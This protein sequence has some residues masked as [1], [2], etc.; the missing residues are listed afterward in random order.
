M[1]KVLPYQESNESYSELVLLREILPG[2]GSVVPPPSIDRAT[3]FADAQPGVGSD[4]VVMDLEA[5]EEVVVDELEGQSN[6]SGVASSEDSV[7]LVEKDAVGLEVAVGHD[8][9]GDQVSVSIG[10][11][12]LINKAELE[13]VCLSVGPFQDSADVDAVISS[14]GDNVITSSMSESEEPVS[15]DNW[16]LIPSLGS[17]KEALKML[18]V[19]QANKIDSYLVTEGVHSNAISLGLFKKASSA[20]GVLS[21]MRSA[22]YEAEIH[23]IERFEK[24]YTGVLMAEFEVGSAPKMLSQLIEDAEKINISKSLCEMFASIP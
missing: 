17:R 10:E 9:E 13:R 18:K 1:A 4:E 2:E 12:G 3:R 11:E 21:K 20:Q 24:R 7:E 22:G 23:V 5:A 14:L 16:V 6:A 15:A 8:T 19:L